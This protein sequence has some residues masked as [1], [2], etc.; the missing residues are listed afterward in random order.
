MPLFFIYRIF[1]GYCGAENSWLLNFSPV[2]AIA[3]CGPVIFPHRVALVLPLAILLASDMVL[4]AHFG[5]ALV[6]GGMVVR[7]VA[8]ALVRLF[9]SP[10][11][12]SDFES[13]KIEMSQRSG[14]ICGDGAVRTRCR[15]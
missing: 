3:L 13:E 15:G 11:R 9:H 1:A 14:L 6:T 10:L 8:L 2:A 4:N 7:Y 5:A 12:K